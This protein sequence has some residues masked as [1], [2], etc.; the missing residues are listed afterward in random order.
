MAKSSK[1]DQ[2]RDITFDANAI[3]YGYETL[4]N[5]KLK[6]SILD[7]NNTLISTYTSTN[8]TNLNPGDT[9]TYNDLN[10]YSTPYKPT[11]VAD[12]KIV[13][14]LISDSASTVSDTTQF[15]VTEN[16]L[17]I[18]FDVV[19]NTLGTPNLGDDGSALA[20]RIDL[21]DTIR[22][23]EVWARLSSLTVAGGT[24]EIEVYDTIGFDYVAGFPASSLLATST[25]AYTITPTD[26]SN[27]YFQVPVTDGVN[28]FVDLAGPSYFLV[29]R[30]YSNAGS[31]LI[32]IAN[33]KTFNQ[34]RFSSIMY[35]ATNV[36]WY[37]GYTNSYTLNAPLI[38][39]IIAVSGIGVEE[40][41]LKNAI[42]ISPNPASE[43]LTIN[44]S[45]FS[46][47]LDLRLMDISGRLVFQEK[48]D[49]YV[50]GEKKIDVSKL[51]KGV[52]LLTVNNAHAHSSHKIIVN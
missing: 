33:D 39:G 11:A 2:T 25:N 12:Y 14:E 21:V 23:T 44:I 50:S 27:G 41:R 18:D 45:N 17:G 32:R 9:A 29:V 8:N 35:N 48:S 28:P 51:P 20:S 7:A 46:G 22:L 31:N 4:N 10:T 40:D 1:T 26:V 34:P 43:Y 37:S 16:L 47:T 6:V 24:V 52:Y 15:F 19:S 5:V 30:M 3:N 38:R 13:Y 42:A 49:I 36:R